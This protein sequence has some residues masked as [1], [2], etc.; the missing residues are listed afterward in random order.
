MKLTPGYSK[1]RALHSGN[2]NSAIIH[3]HMFH[4]LT[5][6][7]ERLAKQIIAVAPVLSPYSSSLRF[8][9]HLLKNDSVWMSRVPYL[10]S[11]RHRI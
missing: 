3:S 10:F 1:L 4:H 8:N 2:K 7:L 9:E 6:T 5:K 11:K